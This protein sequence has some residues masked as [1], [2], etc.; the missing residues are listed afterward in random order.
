MLYDLTRHETLREITNDTGLA[1]VGDCIVNLCYSVAKSLVLGRLHGER[2]R[3]IILARAIRS[4]CVYES[5]GKRTDVGKA[6]DTYEAIIA[7][8]WLRGLVSIEQ[9]VQVLVDNLNDDISGSISREVAT[10]S[11]AFAS[12]L[13]SIVRALPSSVVGQAQGKAL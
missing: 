1:Q 13:E 6:A 3:D 4:S 8:C 12:L 10:A 5:I 11:V 2:V 7:Y 9:M